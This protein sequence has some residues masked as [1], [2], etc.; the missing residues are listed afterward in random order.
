MP[1]PA[2]VSTCT[3]RGLRHG[4]FP[5]HCLLNEEFS[6]GRILY[7]VFCRSLRSGWTYK[8]PWGM[9]TSLAGPGDFGGTHPY[10]RPSSSHALY[11]KT[12]IPIL[13]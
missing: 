3:P 11:Y 1:Q 2:T 8:G 10:R 7:F 9:L 13:L 5:P 12:P 6:Q 4:L